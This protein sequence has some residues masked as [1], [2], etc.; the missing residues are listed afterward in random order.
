M[1]SSGR[2]YL[3]KW[4]K[5]MTKHYVH[6]NNCITNRSNKS[7]SILQIRHKKHEYRSYAMNA[8]KNVS[9]QNLFHYQK[10]RMAQYDQY[11]MRT[12]FVFSLSLF[13]NGLG[14]YTV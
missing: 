2:N 8:I 9:N 12:K 3:N 5:I 14:I 7:D 11:R 10:G 4:N 6:N 13:G 1:H